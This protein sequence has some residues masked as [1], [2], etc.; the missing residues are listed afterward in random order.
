MK[1]HA[2]KQDLYRFINCII[3]TQ[4]SDVILKEADRLGLPVDKI[5]DV[6]SLNNGLAPHIRASGLIEYLQMLAD[7]PDEE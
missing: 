1:H 5:H 6:I 3:K 7:D 2:T 4:N